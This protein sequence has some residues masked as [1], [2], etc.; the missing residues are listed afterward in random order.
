MTGQSKPPR[1]QTETAK[2]NPKIRHDVNVLYKK[3]D[4]SWF[5]FK[6]AFNKNEI[7]TTL[8]ITYN[9]CEV[10]K[11]EFI[12]KRAPSIDY[13]KSLNTNMKFLDNYNPNYLN[14]DAKYSTDTIFTPYNCEITDKTVS[15]KLNSKDPTK[16]SN[17]FSLIKIN[18]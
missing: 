15:S 2:K 9:P 12:E 7:A 6:T 14:I 17:L 13:A 5:E 10:R 3:Y 16:Q 1:K 11:T 8:N 4:G 18:R